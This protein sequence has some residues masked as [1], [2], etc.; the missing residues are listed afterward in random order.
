MTGASSGIGAATAQEL[1]QRGATVVL[2]ARRVEELNQ[3]DILN[4]ISISIY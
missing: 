2:A 3:I 4:N 1:A